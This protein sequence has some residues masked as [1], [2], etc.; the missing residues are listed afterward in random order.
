MKLR[1]CELAVATGVVASGAAGENGR[2]SRSGD[3]RTAKG[4]LASDAIAS[5]KEVDWRQAKLATSRSAT[6]AMRIQ[7]QVLSIVINTLYKYTYNKTDTST[8][9]GPQLLNLALTY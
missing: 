2:G 9:T 3:Q 4:S 8:K 6:R 7:P 1:T 5:E